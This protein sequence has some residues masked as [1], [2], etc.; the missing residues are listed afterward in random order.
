M[1]GVRCCTLMSAMTR[2][3][4]RKGLPA[5]LRRFP[6]FHAGRTCPSDGCAVT[7]GPGPFVDEDTELRS[8]GTRRFLG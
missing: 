7:G 4:F 2:N 6:S 1:P 8:L 5:R 3:T